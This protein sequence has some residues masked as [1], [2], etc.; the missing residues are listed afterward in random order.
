[1]KPQTVRPLHLSDEQ[2]IGACIMY[3]FAALNWNRNPGDTRQNN[4]D[5]WA[6][7]CMGRSSK[8]KG[9][10]SAVWW[11]LRT[12]ADPG[13]SEPDAE[14]W[15]GYLTHVCRNKRLLASY[16]ELAAAGST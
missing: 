1:M 15:L 16:G 14:S 9:F 6:V 3:L 11:A 12:E 2:R 4:E 5:S 10:V 8:T 7:F 13:M